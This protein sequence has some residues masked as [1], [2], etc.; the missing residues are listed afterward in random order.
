M[1]ACLGSIAENKVLKTGLKLKKKSTLK[2]TEGK[3]Q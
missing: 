1:P 2:P 3:K